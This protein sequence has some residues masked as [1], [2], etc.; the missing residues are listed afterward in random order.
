MKYSV[1][2]W[3]HGYAIF[4]G[5]EPCLRPDREVLLLPSRPLSEAVAAEM[6]QSGGGQLYA[7]ACDYAALRQGNANLHFSIKNAL[8]RDRFVALAL[9]KRGQG[10]LPCMRRALRLSKAMGLYPPLTDRVYAY[11][12]EF[13][14]CRPT[15][16]KVFLAYF[17]ER[18]QVLLPAVWYLA[19]ELSVQDLMDLTIAVIHELLEMSQDSEFFQQ[20]RE[21]FAQE[22]SVLFRFLSF[23]LPADPA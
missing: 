3:N 10:S 19:G 16:E 7:M 18:N 14:K 6:S 22:N 2:E 12:T 13:I 15:S 4:L 11:V 21:K 8:L 5:N 20:A 9:E 17:C 1:S 23:A